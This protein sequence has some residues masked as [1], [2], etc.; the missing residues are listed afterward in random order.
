MKQPATK[1]PRE[2]GLDID[3]DS[4]VN[5]EPGDEMPKG[6]IHVIEYSAYEIALQKLEDKKEDW[7]QAVKERD[8]MRLEKDAWEIKY[9]TVKQEN[10]RL[11]MA[12][13]RLQALI[14]RQMGDSVLVNDIKRT[15]SR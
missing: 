2:Y 6:F 13:D 5:H 11:K 8:G 15:L 7:R 1:H 12:M 14:D 4:I 10:E 9:D 3:A